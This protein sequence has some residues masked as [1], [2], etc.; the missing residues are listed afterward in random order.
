MAKLFLRTHDRIF[1]SRPSTAA[2]KLNLYN[3]RS[4]ENTLDSLSTF[5]LKKGKFC[6]CRSHTLSREPIMLKVHLSRSTQSMI[7]RMVLGRKYFSELK[8]KEIVTLVEFQEM[9]RSFSC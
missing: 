5:V 9:L 8:E 7:C 6:S 3:G 1:A 4:H 2:G